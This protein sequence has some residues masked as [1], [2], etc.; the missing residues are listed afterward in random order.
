MNREVTVTVSLG[1]EG[2]AAAAQPPT[3][4][5]LDQVGAGLSSPPTQG[6][7]ATTAG[8]AGG[9]GAAPPVPAPL[10]QLSGSAAGARAPTPAPLEQ[11]GAGQG[12]AGLGAPPAPSSLEAL[13]RGPEAGAPTPDQEPPDASGTRRRRS[14]SG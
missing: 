7:P 1:P 14:S 4:A 10:E 11:L 5:P 9:R 3:P 13:G 6:A 12:A 2:G 8:A